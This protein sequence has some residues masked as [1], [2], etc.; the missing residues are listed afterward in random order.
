M[1]L[2]HSITLRLALFTSLIIAVWAFIFYIT[3]I[4][5]IND[6]TDDTLEDYAE[7]LIQR[8]LRKEPLPSVS[9]G[10]NNQFFLQ[11]ISEAEAKSLPKVKY[12]DREVYIVEKHEYEPAR[13]Y[14]NIFCDAS[15]TYY[16]LEVSTPHIDKSDMKVAL[17]FL[18]LF[19][20]GGI[21]LAIVFLDLWTVK[22]TLRPL[23]RAW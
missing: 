23:H 15:G 20:F 6:E 13:V 22:Y 19:L 11:E 17:L 14:T 2:V 1:K 8:S 9:N 21:L 18:L 7:M 16:R 10:T 12:E 4:R 3:I 5:E